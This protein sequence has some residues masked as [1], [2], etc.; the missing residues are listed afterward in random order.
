MYDFVRNISHLL[1]CT[2]FKRQHDDN[3]HNGRR[4]SLTTFQ[5]PASAL[6]LPLPYNTVPH[7]SSEIHS[8]DDARAL[9][10]IF[11][12]SSSIRGYHTA[13][14]TPGYQPTS[15]PSL[16]L[17]FKFGEHSTSR[18]TSR[19]EKLG[20]HIRQK[21][22]G[23]HLS[24]SSSRKSIQKSSQDQAELQGIAEAS[25]EQEPDI[26]AASHSTAGLS[27]L[28]ASA[29]ASQGGYDSDAKS[30]GSPVLGSNAGTITI[31][32]GFVKQALEKFET[33]RSSHISIKNPASRLNTAFDKPEYDHT[34]SS[35]LAT[36]TSRMSFA[37]SLKIG[38]NES[39]K[40][41]LRRVSTGIADGTIQSPS[42]SDLRTGRLPSITEVKSDWKLIPP[43]RS[44]SLPR[45]CERQMLRVPLREIRSEP[46]PEESER[47]EHV[48][49]TSLISELDPRVLDFVT[50]RESTDS[51]KPRNTQSEHVAAT[52]ASHRLA[53]LTPVTSEQG[54]ARLGS[55]SGSLASMSV[56][57]ESFHLFNMRISQR[58]AS[59]TH[60]PTRSATMSA[61]ASRR[62]F[63]VDET[64][65]PQYSRRVSAE[66]NRQPSDPGTRRLFEDLQNG[67]DHSQ[68][69]KTVT[70]AHSGSACH[71]LRP[72]GMGNASSW[73][74]ATPGTATN[75][76][77]S[78]ARV[79]RRKSQANPHSL[80]VAGRSLSGGLVS[81][82]S[83]HSKLAQRPSD[84][85]SHL[86]KSLNTVHAAE[87]SRNGFD[88]D[89]EL[90]V[91]R[92]RWRDSQTSPTPISR[93]QR[94]SIRCT[95]DMSEISVAMALDR[96]NEKLT[97]IGL[98]E[99]S[100][101]VKMFPVGLPMDGA[102]SPGQS[103]ESSEAR[104]DHQDISNRRTKS[105]SRHPSPMRECATNVW[106]RAFQQAQDM[107]QGQDKFL[108]VPRFDR[109]G[110][111][112]NLTSSLD[113]GSSQLPHD[114]SAASL[115]TKRSRS[116]DTGFRTSRFNINDHQHMCSMAKDPLSKAGFGP[117]ADTALPPA[118]FAID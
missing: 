37:E 86:E 51:A 24:K 85:L 42:S 58:L 6:S 1:C 49:R 7:S 52:G 63:S 67:R 22:S 89:N 19:I 95:E 20:G 23:S 57:N 65:M 106:T 98:E 41:L 12:S 81:P 55:G 72:V 30:L 80:A 4:S 102:K 35:Q 48:K 109:D 116:V 78:T 15:R 100:K 18:P 29:N 112:K 94:R 32:S 110:R 82:P 53:I 5:I 40:Q 50:H 90:R 75:S 43:K 14:T 47:H 36:S 59:R 83:H 92:Q 45:A 8:I 25:P 9:H 117:T 39:P 99:M 34:Q 21:L 87:T 96:R 60:L 104:P 61:N 38:T 108:T 103:G 111:R 28:L 101:P 74:L 79:T 115:D 91:P 97:E 68:S 54:M 27:G 44:S 71:N 93:H 62:S 33:R 69:W 73:H 105:L 46:V 3:D 64:Q 77:C 113:A 26:V 10:H 16:D 2:P 70:S 88:D 11:S 107:P 17:D 56:D 84:D 13:A 76:Y 66:H 118:D 114:G 31:S